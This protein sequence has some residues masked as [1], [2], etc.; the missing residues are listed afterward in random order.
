MLDKSNVTFVL[1]HGFQT[2]S[3]LLHRKK[4]YNATCA[5]E[6]I[7]WTPSFHSDFDKLPEWLSADGFSDIRFTVVPCNHET[8]PS[9]E[10]CAVCVRTQILSVL[11]EAPDRDIIII[12]HSLGGLIARGYLESAD[13]AADV[14]AHKRA[15]VSMVFTVGTPH[16]SM[17]FNRFLRLNL[18]C[19]APNTKH[20]VAEQFS[21]ST[22]MQEFNKQ[23]PMISGTRYYA[24]GGTGYNGL[25]GNILGTYIHFASGA[26]DATVPTKSAISLEGAVQ[27][28]V[29][30][31]SHQSKIGIPSYFMNA[32][33]QQYSETYA[34]CIRPVLL[35][36]KP[37]EADTLIDDSSGVSLLYAVLTGTLVG[38][39]FTLSYLRYGL[40][41]LRETVAPAP[42]QASL[43]Q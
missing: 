18:G 39:L 33:G 8:A 1:I 11:K 15:F 16:Q 19:D 3:V 10:E 7:R 41:V 27:T 17:N 35:E 5:P 2:T 12:A 40:R 14:K 31:D 30:H 32:P 21:S 23:Y 22:F 4:V 13:Y 26:N 6:P 24:I 38:L 43:K 25:A 42:S 9:I 34:K 29:T 20:R 36:D 28:A 37:M